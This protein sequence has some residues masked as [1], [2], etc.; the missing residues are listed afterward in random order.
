MVKRTGARNTRRLHNTAIKSLTAVRKG[1]ES[2]DASIR[3]INRRLELGLTA[4]GNPGTA[5][6]DE[7]GRMVPEKVSAASA[8]GLILGERSML[9]GFRLLRQMTEEVT[10]AAAH[11]RTMMTMPDPISALTAQTAYV[12]A[13]SQRIFDA[14]LLFA[15][16]SVTMIDAAGTPLH[17]TVMANAKRLR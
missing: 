14:S 15:S 13:A 5:D 3:V 4:I 8:A 16:S 17:R 11:F 10:R 2:A 6:Y 9:L 7:F 1:R 12:T